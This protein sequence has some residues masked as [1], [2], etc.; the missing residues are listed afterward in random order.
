MVLVVVLRVLEAVVELVT[1]IVHSSIV[2]PIVTRFVVVLIVMDT[3]VMTVMVLCVIPVAVL[4][5]EEIV[6]L[7]RHAVLG[8]LL[9]DVIHHVII[10]V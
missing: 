2:K 9:M 7:A 6:N 1:I 3:Q 8:V 4:H 10:C 5:V